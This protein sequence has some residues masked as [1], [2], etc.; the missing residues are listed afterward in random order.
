MTDTKRPNDDNDLPRPE[1]TPVD[2]LR[3]WET[4]QTNPGENTTERLR[5]AGGFLY[6]TTTESG[7]VALAFVPMSL[8]GPPSAQ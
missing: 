4:V 7:A 6:R 1:R 5:V 3:D 2:E 8:L